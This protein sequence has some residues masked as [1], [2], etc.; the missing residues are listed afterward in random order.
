MQY[1]FFS[2]GYAEN[3]KVLVTQCP[4]D[5]TVVD[6]WT[7]V[8]DHDSNIVVL[9]DQLNKVIGIFDYFVSLF[10]VECHNLVNLITIQ[11]NRQDFLKKNVHFAATIKC[12]HRPIQ[13]RL[14]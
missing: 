2:Q 9:L 10:D 5:K 4:L 6:F 13:K 12:R 14:S 8:Y 11:K 7:M 3:S 1:I